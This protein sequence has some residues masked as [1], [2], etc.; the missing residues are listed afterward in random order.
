MIKDNNLFIILTGIHSK[1][2][3]F[4]MLHSIYYPTPQDLSVSLNKEY[5][6]IFIHTSRIHIWIFIILIQLF[7]VITF[8]LLLHLSHREKDIYQVTSIH[9]S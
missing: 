7:E 9:I 5:N 3:F 1:Y 4:D 6:L 2:T 8:S